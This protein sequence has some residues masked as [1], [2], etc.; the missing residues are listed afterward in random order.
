MKKSLFLILCLVST[1]YCL[2]QDQLGIKIA[3]SLSYNRIHT[4]PDTANFSSD[5]IALRGK[6]GAIYDW[7]IRDNYC[8]STGLFFAANQ[9]A[10]KND[11]LAIKEQHELQYIQL[12]LLLKLYTSEIMLDTRLYVELG[13]VGAL[14][15]NDRV[16]KLANDKP[17]IQAF[18]VWELSG[19]FGLGIE[20]NISLFTSIFVGISYQRG[21]SSVLGEQQDLSDVPKA[22]GYA[23]WVSLDLGI[24]F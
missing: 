22:F 13:G 19:L 9:F 3:P 17:F 24:K 20:Y 7:T 21:L 4:N 23:D 18:R 8:L 1:T 12:P 16:T 6:L 15:I 10:I 14:K 5:G 11:S 2:A